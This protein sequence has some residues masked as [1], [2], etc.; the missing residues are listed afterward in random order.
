MSLRDWLRRRREETAGEHE[1][2]KGGQRPADAVR[3]EQDGRADDDDYDYESLDEDDPTV[4]PL[5]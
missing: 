4:Y 1:P 3:A 2:G 5:W